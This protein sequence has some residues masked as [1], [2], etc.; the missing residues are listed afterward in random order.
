LTAILFDGF[1][2]SATGSLTN[3]EYE[4]Y[5]EAPSPQ[6]PTGDRSGERFDAVPE[7]TFSLAA[8]YRRDLEFGGL[9]LRADY[10]WQDETPL[11]AWNNPLDPNNAA[12]I[13]AT[14]QPA[15]GVLNARASLSLGDGRYEIAVWGRNLGDNRDVVSALV[16][17]PF[18]YVSVQRREPMTFGVT[19][20]ARFGGF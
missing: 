10:S 1:E 7:K 16:V 14:T 3:P 4:Q 2:V 15:G 20:T 5:R 9:M 19:G 18:G 12:M 8:T 6:N 11:S 13:A 17:D